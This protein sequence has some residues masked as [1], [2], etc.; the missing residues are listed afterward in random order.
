MIN[1]EREKYLKRMIRQY[2]KNYRRISKSS[3]ESL[4]LE[5]YLRQNGFTREEIIL[6]K[7]LQ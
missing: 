3:G 5:Q 7:K 6:S 4:S 1:E 2:N